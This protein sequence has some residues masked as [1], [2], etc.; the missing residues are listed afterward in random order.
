MSSFFKYDTNLRIMRNKAI[1]VGHFFIRRPFW[2][3]SGLKNHKK[4]VILQFDKK[5]LCK[6]E[7]S[8]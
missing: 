7:I 3:M 5:R 8:L 6:R 4:A 2:Q 1:I